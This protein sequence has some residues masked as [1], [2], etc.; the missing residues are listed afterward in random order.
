MVALTCLAYG[1]FELLI[2]EDRLP[3]TTMFAKVM[4]KVLSGS[5]LGRSCT[6]G[7]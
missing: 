2:G 5:M 4:L 1:A 3:L 6:L 7:L